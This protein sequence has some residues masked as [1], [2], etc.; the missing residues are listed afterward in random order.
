MTIEQGPVPADG[1][2]AHLA[3]RAAIHCPS[4]ARHDPE[5]VQIHADAGRFYQA[6]LEGARYP[7][8]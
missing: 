7:G 6:C 2:L 8:T 4:V 1:D 5:L 3:T